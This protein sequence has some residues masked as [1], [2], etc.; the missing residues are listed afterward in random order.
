MLT[1][2][3]IRHGETDANVQKIFRGRLDIPLND[4]GRDQ[5]A[6]VGEVFRDIPVAKIYTSPLRRTQETAAAVAETTGAEV[7]AS[8]KLIDIDFGHWQGKRLIDVAR[9]YTTAYETWAI[10]PVEA[11]IPNGETLRAVQ[12]RALGE[13]HNVA[14]KHPEGHIAVVSHRV[15]LKV[16]LMGIMGIDLSRFRSIRQDTACINIV[17]VEEGNFTITRMN[18]THHLRE[19]MRGETEADF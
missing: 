8:Q 11:C 2:Y 16:L 17:T 7:V 3:I 19:I 1:I 13:L 15:V 18:D 10:N 5:V 9:E 14:R 6:A 4:R 12:S